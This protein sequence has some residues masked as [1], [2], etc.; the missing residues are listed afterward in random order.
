[1]PYV[2]IL[3]IEHQSKYSKS[4]CDRFTF[5][6]I[7]RKYSR[8]CA[9]LT[10]AVV[11]T[12]HVRSSEMCVPRNLKLT[13]F[14][15]LMFSGEWTSCFFLK[16][17]MSYFVF[18]GCLVW[19]CSL[20]ITLLASVPP[21]CRQTHCLCHH[22]SSTNLTMVLV[23]CNENAVMC[24]KRVEEQAQH[25]ALLGPCAECQS[26][27][28]MRAHPDWLWSICQI[29]QRQK[30]CGTPRSDILENS[31]RDRMGLN[32]ELWSMNSSSAY[33]HVVP[34]GA[35]QCGGQWRLC[36]PSTCLLCIG[37]GPGWVAGQ[38]WC[39][40]G[41][42]S[43][44]TSQW[45]V[46]VPR[47]CI[48][49]GCYSSL[50]W[51]WHYCGCLQAGGDFAL[52]Q[53]KV[54]VI[55]KYLTWFCSTASEDPP[56]MQS[57][58]AAFRGLILRSVLVTSANWVTMPGCWWLEQDRRLSLFLWPWSGRRTGWAAP[59]PRRCCWCCFALWCDI[60][61]HHRHA[62]RGSELP[63]WSSILRFLLWDSGHVGGILGVQFLNLLCQNHLLLRKPCQDGPAVVC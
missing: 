56:R 8:C 19:D 10:S 40:A 25:T 50:L 51:S 20:C 35:V 59:P 44:G 28:E 47:T 22:S 26:R 27:G 16:P 18:F 14:S 7:L 41:Q 33:A 2:R 57:G 46:S 5:F 42:D 54:E 48:F 61:C 3:S 60:S 32:A 6:S 49:E 21:L 45:Q 34:G 39:V 53:K 4:C 9:F 11:F 30:L 12:V 24:I 36:C 13:T 52:W 43:P 15:P 55:W 63:K 37:G 23:M 1:M 29:I 17:L 38:P 62:R 31:L 58:P